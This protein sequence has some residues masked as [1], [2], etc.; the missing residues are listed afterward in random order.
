MEEQKM[1]RL[2]IY[3]LAIFVWSG[4]S[5]EVAKDCKAPQR[6]SIP[7]G[8]NTTESKLMATRTILEQ[9]LK[10]GDS[11]LVCLREFEDNLGDTITE[12]DGHELLA[13]YKGMVEEMYLAGDEYNIALRRFK[14]NLAA[15]SGDEE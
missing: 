8:G 3:L 12:I 14:L 15:S 6:P 13:K 1:Q 4:S 5:A 9:Y 10:D 7:D 11:Y 2:C